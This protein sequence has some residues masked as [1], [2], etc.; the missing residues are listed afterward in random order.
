M[1]NELH[2]VLGASG[3]SGMAVIRA[4]RNRKLRIRAV[5]RRGQVPGIETVHADLLQPKQVLDAVQ[6][7]T[8]VY[9]CVGLPY[10][11]RVWASEWPL[12]MKQV[13]HACA[14]N[15]ARL[16]FLDNAYM[17]GP[18]PL[19]T[20]F[21]EQHPQQPI[22]KKG[23]ARKEATECLLEA[24]A[25]NRLKAVIGRSADF[26]G[27]YAVNSMWYISFLEN[28]LRGKPP[29]ILGREQIPHTYAYTLDNGR[30][31]V[32]LALD[33]T[34][35]GQVWHLPVGEPITFGEILEGCNRELGTT[36]K[37]EYLQ[38]WLRKVLSVFIPPIREVE[39]MLYQFEHPYVMND[40]KFK[41]HFPDFKTTP[42]QQGL[43]AMIDSFRQTAPGGH[44]A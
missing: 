5:A 29:Q 18:A 17:Y 19:S 7:A 15:G 37:L 28:M 22:S 27:P 20:P 16:I 25:D 6:D 12:L 8:H 10:R 39:E 40:D 13:I 33:E 31:L 4:L 34:T 42:F 3:A 1:T 14:R 30:A 11:A 44:A 23:A 43:R 35:F 24:M 26:Y 38:P 2:T 32:A 9:L 41:N 21:N 36:F